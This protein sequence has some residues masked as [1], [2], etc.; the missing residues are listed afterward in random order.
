MAFLNSNGVM[1]SAEHEK[2]RAKICDGC[3]YNGRVKPTILLPEMDGCTACG[4]PFETK[5]K[6]LQFNR[7]VGRE[8]LPLDEKEIA[9][10]LLYKGTDKVKLIKIECSHPE[11]NKWAEIDKKYQ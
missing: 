4:C 6:Q 1:V 3:E 10:I 2:E 7:M 5:R 8:D 11:G 9:E